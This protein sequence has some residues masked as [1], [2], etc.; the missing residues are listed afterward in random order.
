V[1]RRI[2]AQAPDLRSDPSRP[3][4]WVA[5]AL[6]I[7]LDQPVRPL[8]KAKGGRACKARFQAF[9]TPES[10][11]FRSQSGPVQEKPNQRGGRL[12]WT[13]RRRPRAPP[14][15]GSRASER[16]PVSRE[17][18]G[19]GGANE[20]PVAELRDAASVS[21]AACPPGRRLY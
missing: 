20:W 1:G 14:R 3:L 19:D 16:T 21:P 2:G 5:S 15:S 9:L 10:E 7:R 4:R 13:G 6:L 11:G 18:M 8:A 17:A 12:R